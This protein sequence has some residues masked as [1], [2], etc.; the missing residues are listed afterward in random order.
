MAMALPGKSAWAAL[1]AST[2][3][4]SAE[5]HALSQFLTAKS[6]DATL[7]D[8]ALSALT[9]VDAVFATQASQLADFI[10]Q[11]GFNDIEALKTAASFNETYRSTALKIIASLYMGFAGTPRPGHAEDDTQFVT[12]TQALMYRLTYDYVPIPS[13]SRWSTGYWTSVPQ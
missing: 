6:L 13:Y 3:N 11:G 8:R 9:K 1:Q 2:G 10:R 4:G 7:T 12:Y 5:F